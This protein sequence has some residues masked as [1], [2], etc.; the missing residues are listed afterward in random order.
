MSGRGRSNANQ[1]LA[2]YTYEQGKRAN[3]PTDQTERYMD[4]EDLKPIPYSPERRAAEGPLLSWR[5]GSQLDD[6]E[7]AA[8]PLF[9][10][11]KVS[12]TAF[13]RQL[14]ENP[15]AEGLFEAFNNLPPDAAFACYQYKG[16]WSNRLIKGHSENVMASLAAKEGLAGEIQMIYWDPPYGISYNSNF[17]PNTR[18][19]VGGPPTG[20][21]STLAFRDTYRD[22]IHSYLDAVYRT[23]V[24]GRA[25]LADSGSFFLQINSENVHRLALVLD[26]AFGSENRMAT[27]PFAKT[28][29]SSSRT[30]PEICDYLLWYAKDKKKVK[31]HQLYESLSRKQKLQ[32]MSSY[33]MVELSDGRR[34]QLTPEERANPDANLPEGARL[35]KRTDLT[36][37][38]ESTTGRSRPFIWNEKEYPCPVGRHWSVDHEGLEQLARMKRL[39]VADDS[40]YLGWVKY[41]NEIPGRQ[42]NNL[43]HRQMSPNELHYVVETAESVI[44]RCLLMATDP[45]DLVLDPTCGSGTTAFVSEKWGRR[46]ITIDASAVPIA[47]CRQRIL[48]A[49]HDW[50]YTMDDPEGWRVELELSGGAVNQREMPGLSDTRDPYSGFVHERVPYVS[51]ATLAYDRPAEP[52]VLVDQ[53]R[54]KQGW[55]RVSSSFTVES[56]S[57]WRYEP[58]IGGREESELRQ[59]VRSRILEALGRAGFPVEEDGSRK[60]W[61]LDDIENWPG[62]QC[63]TNEAR[64]R[65]TGERIALAVL[66]DDQTATALFIDRATEEAA[67][68]RAFKKLL[69]CAFEFASDVYLSRH[70]RRGRLEIVKLRANRDLAI[71]ELKPS[72]RDRAFILVGEPELEVRLVGKDQLEVE[73]LGWNTFDPATGSVSAGKASEIDCW[74][75]D[76]NHD[77]KSFFARRVHFPGR[78]SD[79]QLKRFKRMLGARVHPDQWK[80][81]ESLVSAPFDRPS[82]GRVAIR[83]VTSTGDEML[84]VREVPVA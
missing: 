40:E 13:A 80:T 73:V 68:R 38:G 12:P 43:W 21:A 84:A 62:S 32:L 55:K 82:S 59:G 31:F 2:A 1:P 67:G 4:E 57:P 50:Y 24:H 77:G 83:I 60:R 30:I 7:I 22:G 26:E 27:I 25:L 11:E 15:G 5:R 47:L 36:S 19:R 78:E 6:M 14:I 66:S 37:Q 79:P 9:I 49:V 45:G 76:T 51:P 46:W 8:G 39:D 28:S 72:E 48:A 35:Y 16:N 23:A 42:I 3:L 54:K 56:H 74:L 33:A 69:V 53:P 65:E 41:E 20:A 75:L 10:H 58:I 71:A 70:E 61:H 17:Q 34:R 81:M 29:A 44:E 63:L 52:T 64:V 18:K